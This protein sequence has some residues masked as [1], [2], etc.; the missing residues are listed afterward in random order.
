M[1]LGAFL[2]TSTIKPILVSLLAD[3]NLALTLAMIIQ[4][5]SWGPAVH[6]GVPDNL[7]DD[8]DYNFLFDACVMPSPVSCPACPAQPGPQ[9]GHAASSPRN[10]LWG[11]CIKTCS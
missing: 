8:S 10:S 6:A 4:Y 2:N 3:C 7:S 11:T 9:D 5:L 1:P